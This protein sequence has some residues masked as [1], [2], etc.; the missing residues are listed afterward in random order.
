MSNI[1]LFTEFDALPL[2]ASHSNLKFVT[3]IRKRN[4]EHSYQR[5]YID[6]KDTLIQ[7]DIS[8]QL[9]SRSNIFRIKRLKQPLNIFPI[10]SLNTPQLQ[11]E[12]PCI[13]IDNIKRYLLEF[14]STDIISQYRIIFS[15]RKS[16]EKNDLIERITNSSIP[17]EVLNLFE[18]MNLNAKYEALLFFHYIIERVPMYSLNLIQ[19]GMLQM[20]LPLITEGYIE[21]VKLIMEML[22]KM[23]MF[24]LGVRDMILKNGG[25][26]KIEIILLTSTNPSLVLI[27]LKAL[28]TLLQAHHI[29]QYELTMEMIERFIHVIYIFTFNTELMGY[30]LLAIAYT[31]EQYSNSISSIISSGILPIVIHYLELDNINLIIITLRLFGNI[32]CGNANETQSLLDIG[33]L[34]LLIRLIASDNKLIRQETTWVISNI[35]AGT[36]RQAESLSQFVPF[37][38]EIALKDISE[39]STEAIYA[40]CNCLSIDEN[41]IS[42]DEVK[43]IEFLIDQNILTVMR[44]GLLNENSDIISACLEALKKLFQFVQKMGTEEGKRIIIGKARD[45]L[46]IDVIKSMSTNPSLFVFPKVRDIL[47]SIGL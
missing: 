33:L 15:L 36:E 23:A 44:F 27:A 10:K 16:M 13:E 20:I 30:A 3:K 9:E 6:V 24:S 26:S 28:S 42:E 1:S 39:I 25:H 41:T 46:L 4:E 17:L 34:A 19:G 43:Y 29:P 18:H 21:I 31:T 11:L 5:Y 37:L 14:K 47:N 22:S 45:I 8:K 7:E 32:I 38:V 12:E 35:A 40:L 2:D